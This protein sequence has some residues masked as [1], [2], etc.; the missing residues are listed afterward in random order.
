M[1]S[2]T[3][4]ISIIND[5]F[6]TY[7]NN[8]Y[9]LQR[10]DFH[11][12]N[13]S[14]VLNAEKDSHDKRIMRTTKLETE[15]ATFVDV[16]LNKN[17]YY[18]LQDSQVGCFYEYNGIHYRVI[19]ED[20]IHHKI[21]TTIPYDNTLQDWKYKTKNT[22]MKQI[23]ATS[24]F[25]TTPESSTIQSVLK[26][27]TPAIFTK[28]DNAKY[29]LT[30]IGDNILKKNKD[31]IYLVNGKAKQFLSSLDELSHIT[32]GQTNVTRNFIKYHESHDYS[33]CR[34]IN[35]A[36]DVE[37][38]FNADQ[39]LDF[40]CVACHYSHRFG[41]ADDYIVKKAN[42]NVK[43]YT[44]M[45]KNNSKEEIVT[46]FCENMIEHID[47]KNEETNTTSIIS[48]KDMHYLWK[49]YLLIME[50]PSMMYSATLKQ[51]LIQ[52]YEYSSLHDSF[53]NITSKH[54]PRICS[55]ID[56]WNNHIKMTEDDELE[57]DELC[58]LLKSKNI[59]IDEKEIISIIGHFFTNITI[60]NDKYL[61]KVSCDL[62]DKKKDIQ[63][64][65][66]S[67]KNKNKQNNNETFIS[68][69]DAYA[70]YCSMFSSKMVVSKTY[71]EKYVTIMLTDYIE[72]DSFIS[73]KWYT[74]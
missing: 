36:D 3:K 59:T 8:D 38:V 15:H 40:F 51:I 63:N 10:F 1:D 61:L 20:D 70:H 16:F 45:L 32:I 64:A 5:I 9:M 41:N 35:I 17:R 54:L 60:V 23:K 68:F 6:E 26:R 50:L 18:Y 65:L 43:N 44:L 19:K 4:Y 24:L 29:F 67:L 46:N 69:E 42:E 28:R 2:K 25:S 49:T 72:Y 39:S 7:K 13:L 27:L 12:N 74:T 37:D 34:L 71:F 30:I 73:H 62:W 11:M 31:L 33:K 48:W 66:D 56:F 21:F 52:R 57:I 22:I 55:L 47:E 14:N 53:I 58:Y